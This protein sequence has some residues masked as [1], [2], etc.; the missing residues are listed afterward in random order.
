M[1]Q[2][3]YNDN[4]TGIYLGSF[5]T[6]EEAALAYNRAAKEKDGEYANLNKLTER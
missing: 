6:E 4:G 1:F 2:L 3:V 5:K